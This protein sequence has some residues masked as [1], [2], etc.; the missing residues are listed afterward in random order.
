MSDGTSSRGGDVVSLIGEDGAARA[1]RVHDAIE[2]DGRS[3]YLVEAVD[4]PD[5]VL[6]LRER[7]GSL[8]AVAGAEL[9]RV[10]DELERGADAE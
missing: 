3:Y 6:V 2:L 5:Q 9:D 7:G 4:D 1:F 10:L 8:D